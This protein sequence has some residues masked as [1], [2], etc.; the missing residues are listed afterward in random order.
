M[1]PEG[2]R[3]YI[4]D[5]DDTLYEEKQFVRAAMSDVSRYLSEKYDASFDEIYDFCMNSIESGHRGR[6]FNMLCEEFSFDEDVDKIVDIYRSCET[7]LDLYD[8]AEELI[9]KI[10]EEGLRIGVITDGFSKVQRSKVAGLGLFEIADAVI[11]SYD[12]TDE[13]GKPLCKPNTKVYE[14]CLEKLGVKP[15]E[16]VYIGDN[17]L[18]DFVGAR[19]LGMKTVHIKR[20]GSMFENEVPEPGFEADFMIEKLTELL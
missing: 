4:F 2:V 3:A 11:I 18:K 15:E 7:K 12:Y 16:S 20:K 1:K 9:G 6:T 8:D 13:N 5:V 14:M 19:K 10:K 17:P